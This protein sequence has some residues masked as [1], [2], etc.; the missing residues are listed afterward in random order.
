M[1]STLTDSMDMS[2]RPNSLLVSQALQDEDEVLETERRPYAARDRAS[3]LKTKML[4]TVGAPGKPRLVTFDGIVNE[5]KIQSQREGLSPPTRKYYHN[6]RDKNKHSRSPP[7]FDG[8]RPTSWLAQME[9]FLRLT[10]TPEADK[11]DTALLHFRP[12]FM[13]W[14]NFPLSDRS[15]L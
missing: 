4:V 3:E 10:E 13:D 6:H 12:E 5:V 11:L 2:P 8:T 9:I 1:P 7:L 14:Y 15:S